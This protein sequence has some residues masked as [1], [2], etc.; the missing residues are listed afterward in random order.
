MKL[1]RKERSSS[2]IADR[3]RYQMS[4]IYDDSIFDANDDDL[5]K[6]KPNQDLSHQRQNFPRH[7]PPYLM[8]AVKRFVRENPGALSSMYR[9]SR[10]VPD[11]VRIFTDL[12]KVFAETYQLGADSPHIRA[13][14]SVLDEYT[15]GEV[16]RRTHLFSV[17]RNLLALHA[18]LNVC[19]AIY[20]SIESNEKAHNIL[21]G[22]HYFLD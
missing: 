7:I 12:S 19:N 17:Q 13:L 5:L 20:T 21:Y 15:E 9:G 10:L 22:Y 16:S 11:S 6:Q 2:Y 18:N 4:N 14:I 1:L 8:E 3:L